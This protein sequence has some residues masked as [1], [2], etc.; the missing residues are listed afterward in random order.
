MTEHTNTDGRMVTDREGYMLVVDRHT[1]A[2]P[3][4]LRV[5]VANDDGDYM[6]VDITPEQAESFAR[7]LQHA[8][9]MMF[10]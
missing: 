9:R 1:N 6:A 10:A 5:Y 2:A 7:A 8:A 4:L 3:G